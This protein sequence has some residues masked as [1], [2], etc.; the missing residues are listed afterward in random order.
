MK[1]IWIIGVGKFGRRAYQTLAKDA[2]RMNFVLVDPDKN[3]LEQHQGPDCEITA[4]DGVAFL[5]RNLKASHA[6]DWIIPALPVHLA[7]EWCLATLNAPSFRRCEIPSTLDSQVPNA[8]R[9]PD[10]NLYASHAHFRCPDDCDEPDDI[11]TITRRP[12]KE[13]MF[14]L[15]ERLD[16]KPFRSVVIRSHQLGPGIGGY[17]PEQLFRLLDEVE[18]SHTPLLICTACRCHGVITGLKPVGS[19]INIRPIPSG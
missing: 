17:R 10:G 3:N 13:N 1:T 6:P 19:E 15:L 11:C 16:A 4:M 5:R 14:T 9:G 2:D 8:M 7:A 18:H 12:R